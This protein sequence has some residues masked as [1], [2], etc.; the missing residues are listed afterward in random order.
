MRARRKQAT[1]DEQNAQVG[2]AIL[3]RSAR[4]TAVG[5]ASVQPIDVSGTSALCRKRK[6]LQDFR[7]RE[8]GSTQIMQDDESLEDRREVCAG[9]AGDC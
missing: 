2:M 6:S 8:P 9:I 7:R 1:C 3:V 5:A 4:Q